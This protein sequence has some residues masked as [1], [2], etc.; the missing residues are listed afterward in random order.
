MRCLIVYTSFAWKYVGAKWKRTGSK[1]FALCT[2]LYI[3][4]NYS[5]SESKITFIELCVYTLI[6]VLVMDCILSLPNMKFII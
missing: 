6:S 2:F 5:K 1:H 4:K 3:N